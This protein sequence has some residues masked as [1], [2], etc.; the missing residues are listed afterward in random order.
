MKHWLT[1]IKLICMAEVRQ[2]FNTHENLCFVEKQFNTDKNSWLK[3]E[4]GIVARKMFLKRETTTQ[5]GNRL[6]HYYSITETLHRQCLNNV[7]AHFYETGNIIIYVV[8]RILRDEMNDIINECKTYNSDSGGWM[9]SELK[10]TN[11]SNN[12]SE[13]SYPILRLQRQEDRELRQNWTKKL[14]GR[15]KC[16]VMLLGNKKW[17]KRRLTRAMPVILWH[18]QRGKKRSSRRP[19]RAKAIPL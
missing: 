19:T 3:A 5:I 4:D 12:P 10:T 2:L 8:W 16:L 18:H 14:T 6:H 7:K 11:V 17:F 1:L 9:K 15:R 13:M